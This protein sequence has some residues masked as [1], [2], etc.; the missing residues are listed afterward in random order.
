MDEV[1]ILECGERVALA[2]RWHRT[3]AVLPSEDYPTWVNNYL[4]RLNYKVTEAHQL[5]TWIPP[6]HHITTANRSEVTFGSPFRKI[7]KACE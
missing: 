2:L 3:N 7:V 5:T 4:M 6:L 1:D